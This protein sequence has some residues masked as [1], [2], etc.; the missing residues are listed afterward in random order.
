MPID[1]D[2]LGG[3]AA[4]VTKLL[5]L[6]G[7]RRSLEPQPAFELDAALV[8]EMTITPANVTDLRTTMQTLVELIAAIDK[9]LPQVERAGE[10]AIAN[11]AVALRA[12]AL[13]RIGEIEVEVAGREPDGSP[14]AVV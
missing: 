3:E 11:A 10:S 8:A 14:A 7:L 5:A 6:S 13:T 1:G 2:Q 9:R 12:E 4:D